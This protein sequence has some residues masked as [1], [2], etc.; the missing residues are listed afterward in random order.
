M[1]KEDLKQIREANYKKWFERDKIY[2]NNKG[3]ETMTNK[4]T[5]REL[6][7]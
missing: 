5:G 6:E 3:V 1:N 7:I 4:Y 2:M